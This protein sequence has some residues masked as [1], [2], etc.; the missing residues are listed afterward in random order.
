MVHSLLDSFIRSFTRSFAP[1]LTPPVVCWLQL[2]CETIIAIASTEQHAQK[3]GQYGGVQDVLI[4]LRDNVNDVDI[5]EQ[6]CRAL[7][8]LTVCGQWCTHIQELE[9]EERGS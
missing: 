8:S 4:A 3:I 6:A 5:A 7:F 9:E 2:A 1:S